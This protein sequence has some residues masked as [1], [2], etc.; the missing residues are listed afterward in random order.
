MSQ[1]IKTIKGQNYLYETVWNPVSKKNESKCLGNI[2]NIPKIDSSKIILSFPSQAEIEQTDLFKALECG[3]IDEFLSIFV[4]A[5]NADFVERLHVSDP[6]E[7]KRIQD[8]IYSLNNAI[9][10]QG[11]PYPIIEYL[12]KYFV[13]LRKKSP[14]FSENIDLETIPKK[15]KEI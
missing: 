7:L 6:A 14:V 15:Y 2:K 8:T 10:S 13:N 4:T 5:V 1:S 12:Q 3:C 9:V 11:I